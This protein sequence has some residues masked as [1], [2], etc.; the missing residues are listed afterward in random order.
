MKRLCSLLVVAVIG[1]TAALAQSRPTLSILGDSYSTFQGW[2]TPDTNAVWYTVPADTRRTNVKTVSQTWWHQVLKRQGWKLG[3]NNSY[4]GS[5]VCNTGYNDADYTHESFV[6]RMTNLGTPDVIIIFGGTNDS[7]AGA[8]V[9]DYKYSDIRRAD[10]YSFR[11][12]MA[13]M[14]SRLQELYPTA[15]L[16]FILNDGLKE[17][18]TSSVRKICA[19]YNVPVI[20]LSG[21]DKK[22]GHPSVKG[23]KQIADQVCAAL[24][25]G[26]S[27]NASDR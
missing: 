25:K 16:W 26:T 5:T 23:M 7:W 12:A 6:T 8:P 13:F 20:E 10:L 17:S 18:V 14:L 19:H 9:G 22:S 2:L 3:V 4:S 24:D 1:V 27:S 21:I 15:T 11:P